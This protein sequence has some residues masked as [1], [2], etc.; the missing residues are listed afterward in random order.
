MNLMVPLW[1]SDVQPLH[2]VYIVTDE[3]VYETFVEKKIQNLAET[4]NPII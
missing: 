4:S 1:T 2:A 3:L